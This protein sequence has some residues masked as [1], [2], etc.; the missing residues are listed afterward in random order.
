MNQISILLFLGQE[1]QHD[2]YSD[3]LAV[4]FVK[5]FMMLTWNLGSGPRRIF[6]SKPIDEDRKDYLVRV[7]Y[8]DQRAWLSVDDMENITGRSSGNLKHLDVFPM[9]FIGKRN[10]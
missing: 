3:H 9:L 2:Y 8:H 4:S 10:E 1:G 5:G 6:S 7:G